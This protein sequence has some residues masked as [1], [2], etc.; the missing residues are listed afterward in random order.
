MGDRMTVPVRSGP[1]FTGD[2][3]SATG[4]RTLLALGC[5]MTLHVGTTWSNEGETW[6]DTSQDRDALWG[7]GSDCIR[8]TQEAPST[9][10]GQA[11]TWPHETE[12]VLPAVAKT[13]HF[14][15][16]Y[17][18]T[19]YIYKGVSDSVRKPL[20]Y[21]IQFYSFHGLDNKALSPTRQSW[22]TDI[23][24]GLLPVQSQCSP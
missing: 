21:R 6:R 2:S 12:P 20:V 1:Q 10:Q 5:G 16:Y 14:G 23:T 18:S 22:T 19:F 13:L 24:R 4:L 11:L 3:A 15:P 17:W 8:T 7:P 9:S